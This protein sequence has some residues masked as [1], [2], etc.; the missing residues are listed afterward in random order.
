MGPQNLISDSVSAGQ[1]AETVQAY[2]AAHPSAA[3]LEDGRLLFDLRT[4]RY[5]IAESHG[6]CVLQLWSDD[7]NLMRTVVEVRGYSRISGS[8]SAD[9]QA[10]ASG[11]IS[12][13]SAIAR[14]SCSGLA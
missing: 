13:T 2:L 11:I 7:R 4:A 1:L 6:R 10:S 12:R 9:E 3:L 5:S 8:T 14:R